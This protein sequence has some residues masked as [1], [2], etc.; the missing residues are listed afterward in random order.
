MTGW[1]RINIESDQSRY[2]VVALEFGEK[3]KNAFVYINFFSGT[4]GKHFKSFGLLVI[5]FNSIT[6]SSIDNCLSNAK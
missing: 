2:D 1:C 5:V 6:Y 3:R 4:N